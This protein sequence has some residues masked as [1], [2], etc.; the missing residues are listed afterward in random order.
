MFPGGDLALGEGNHG[1]VGLGRGVVEDDGEG[2]T[3]DR[4]S[5]PKAEDGFLGGFVEGD[6]GKAGRGPKGFF[7]AQNRDGGG[8]FL[9]GEGL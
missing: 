7:L 9:G 2:L 8:Y 5:W 4:I 6:G 3:Q 1:F